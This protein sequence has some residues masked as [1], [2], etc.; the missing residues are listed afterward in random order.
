MK[1]RTELT[2]F[3]LVALLSFAPAAGAQVRIDDHLLGETAEQFFSEARE[4]A[5]L[6]ACARGDFANVDRS[7]KKAAK[8]TCAWLSS[9]RQRMV[10]DETGKYVGEVNA[11]NTKT[12]TYVF[13]AGKFVA[14][15]ILFM[16]PDV[17]NNYHGKS[18]AEISTGLKETYGPPTSETIV[19]YQ[20]AYGVPY[21]R[22]QKLWLAE[23]YA[24]QLDEQPGSHGW[25]SVNLYTREWY[26]K[27]KAA[28]AKPPSN[29]L[30]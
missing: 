11:D 13:L 1:M 27:Q 22:H 15:E 14:A 17:S 6:S 2:R 16:A 29:P 8:A 28:A 10:S 12:T 24:I 19:P 20:N 4:G 3:T 26:D 7:I 25:T 21:Q 18:L 5:M 23:S 30:N 9:A